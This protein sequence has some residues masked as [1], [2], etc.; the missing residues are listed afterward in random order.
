VLYF[1]HKKEGFCVLRLG[2]FFSLFLQRVTEYVPAG[3]EHNL[4]PCG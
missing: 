3:E 2:G 4:G 1:A